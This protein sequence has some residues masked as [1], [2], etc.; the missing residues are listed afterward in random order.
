MTNRKRNKL[1]NEGLVYNSINKS[2][3]LYI[4]FYI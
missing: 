3:E 4:I 1:E 2:K